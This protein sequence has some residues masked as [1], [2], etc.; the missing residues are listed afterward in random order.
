M[1]GPHRLLVCV[2]LGIVGAHQELARRH[3]GHFHGVCPWRVGAAEGKD[4]KQGRTQ[5]GRAK[6]LESGSGWCAHGP[7]R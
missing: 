2:R 4:E 7:H 6:G 1:N 3:G 5:A